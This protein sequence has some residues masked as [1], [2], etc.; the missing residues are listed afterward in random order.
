VR[1]GG[2]FNHRYSLSDAVLVKDNH[3]AVLTAGG[4]S[5]TQALREVRARIGHTVHLEVEVDRLDQ[6]E[7]V[8]A[9]GVDTIMLDNFS[10][11]ELREG[12]ALV[13]ERANIEASGGVNLD[14]VRAIAETGVDLISVG[15]LTHSTRSLDL[16]LDVVLRG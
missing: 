5:V 8:L 11:D 13:G 2:G 9:A 14:T 4:L 1:S 10:T 7:E 12:V 6:I 16:G 15:A 3:L